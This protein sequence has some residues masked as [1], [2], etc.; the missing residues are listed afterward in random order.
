MCHTGTERWQYM[1]IMRNRRQLHVYILFYRQSPKG[2]NFHGQSDMVHTCSYHDA[3]PWVAERVSH[4]TQIY[5]ARA[6]GY[7]RHVRG[8]QEA[9]NSFE[10]EVQNAI[11]L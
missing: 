5:R 10:P 7:T 3:P 6:L 1:A 11:T 2:L 9:E 4:L 8:W